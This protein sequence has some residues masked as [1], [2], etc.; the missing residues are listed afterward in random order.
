M[1]VLYCVDRFE[2]EHSRCFN[3]LTLGPSVFI[4]V[5]S[6]A[7]CIYTGNMYVYIPVAHGITQLVSR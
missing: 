1:K 6:V 4:P 3:S 7:K 2:S 5:V